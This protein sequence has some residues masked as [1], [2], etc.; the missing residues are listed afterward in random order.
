MQNQISLNNSCISRSKS[1]KLLKSQK[2]MI[3]AA[4]IVSWGGFVYGYDIGIIS[5][6]LSEIEQK[7]NLNEYE[8]GLVVALLP[9]GSIFGCIIGG[10]T[11]DFIGRW[12]T[13]IL[14]N[15]IYIFG[16]LTIAMGPSIYYIYFGR[17]IIGVATALSGIAD[18]PYLTE[19]S[20][21]HYRGRLCSTYELMAMLGILFAFLITLLVTLYMK[22]DNF[23]YYQVLYTLPAIFALIQMFAMIFLPESPKWLISKNKM[24]EAKHALFFQVDGDSDELEAR[25]ADMCVHVLNERVSSNDDDCKESN[26]STDNMASNSR[27]SSNCNKSNNV[28]SNHGANDKHPALLSSFHSSA[29]HVMPTKS[30]G[31]LN[32]FRLTMLQYRLPLFCAISLAVFQQF[33][34]GVLVRNY[35]PR[36]F[37]NAGFGIE[38]SQIF[39]VLLGIVKVFCCASSM[40]YVSKVLCK[41]VLDE[42][43]Y[44]NMLYLCW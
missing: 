18:I 13:I 12:K 10:P 14:L 30:S 44:C 31:D 2:F 37:L 17:Y 35:A 19:I 42:H 6:T 43:Q 40:Y 4:L 15:V 36:I 22:K 20:S 28:I 32:V 5:G 41:D 33:T 24:E 1:F 23:D 8:T 38:A 39:T 9:L 3:K 7:F 27:G 34:G 11:C 29:S 16:T 25:F 21:P 26:T